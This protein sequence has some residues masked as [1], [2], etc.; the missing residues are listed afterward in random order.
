M[1]NKDLERLAQIP[2]LL[3]IL[4][5]LPYWIHTGNGY[6]FLISIPLLNIGYFFVPKHKRKKKNE[7]AHDYFNRF[8][9]EQEFEEIM[10]SRSRLYTK[11]ILQLVIYVFIALGFLYRLENLLP[12]IP[13][14]IISIGISMA[15]LGLIYNETRYL[16][17]VRKLWKAH[18]KAGLS[19]PS[20]GAALRDSL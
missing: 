20:N 2:I 19:T 5:V 18:I 12:I 9:M 14:L 4:F 15:C 11:R 8:R 17:E 10:K 16:L 6:L 3:G 7:T 13:P 1:R